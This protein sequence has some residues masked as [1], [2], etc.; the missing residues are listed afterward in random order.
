MCSG[1]IALLYD[2]IDVRLVYLSYDRYRFADEPESTSKKTQQTQPQRTFYT[3]KIKLQFRSDG[4]TDILIFNS[5]SKNASSPNDKLVEFQKVWGWDLE[6]SNE[7]S[8]D[9]LLFSA[10]IALPPQTGS[11]IIP[12][13]ERFYFQARVDKKKDNKISLQDGSVTVKRNIESGTGGWWGL[14]RGA[15]GILAQFREVGQFRCK[16]VPKQ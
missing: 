5:Q 1:V 2:L 3:G 12:M 8:L 14:F 16:A 15:D 10:D 13:P 9:Y 4:Y 7:D 11:S 6:T